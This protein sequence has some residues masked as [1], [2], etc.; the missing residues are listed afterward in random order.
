MYSNVRCLTKNLIHRITCRKHQCKD[1]QYIGETKRKNFVDRFT[2]PRGYVD[3]K[4]MDQVC[5]K[6][7][8]QKGRKH[9]DMLPIIFEKVNPK[10]DSFLRLR[11]GNL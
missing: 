7:F 6:H 4:C 8:N 11:R 3:R 2:K 10:N 1:F 5:D 9:E